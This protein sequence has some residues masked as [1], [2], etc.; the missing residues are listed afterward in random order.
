LPVDVVVAVVVDGLVLRQLLGSL[1]V[2][3]VVKLFF[4]TD[5]FSK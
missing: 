5:A 2:V 4:I 1:P 3:K